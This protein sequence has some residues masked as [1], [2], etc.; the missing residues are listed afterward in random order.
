[1]LRPCVFFFKEEKLLLKYN[2]SWSKIEQAKK[3]KKLLPGFG[4]KYLKTE[5]DNKITK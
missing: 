5:I 4:D 3:S 1:M 2:E